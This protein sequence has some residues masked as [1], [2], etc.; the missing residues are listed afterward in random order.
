MKF[1]AYFVLYFFYPIYF[2]CNL[3]ACQTEAMKE[4]LDL[5]RPGYLL[6]AFHFH[7]KLDLVDCVTF[8]SSHKTI[9][10]VILLR[11]ITN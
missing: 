2:N 8:C 5:N 7:L 1:L 9:Y 10:M 3:V 4:I 11:W 6:S